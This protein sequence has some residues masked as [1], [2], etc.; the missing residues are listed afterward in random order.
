M[1]TW[2]EYLQKNATGFLEDLI[3]FCCIPSI[4]SLP[5][6]TDDVKQAAAWVAERLKIAGIEDVQILST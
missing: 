5:E 1:T 4:S 6:H 2:K 3:K